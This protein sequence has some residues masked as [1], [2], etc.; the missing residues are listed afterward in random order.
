MVQFS[1]ISPVLF[2]LY[3]NNIPTPLHH[4]ALA[5]YMVDT[6]IIATSRKLT[7][8]VSYLES[9]PSDLQRWLSDRRITIKVSKSTT[10]IFASARQ[11]FIK[12]R[13]VKLFREPIQWFKT[14][15]MGVTLDTWLT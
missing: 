13:P 8:L 10:I 9:Y 1:I 15:N 3:V 7:L 12:P 6:T 11:H 2:S 14:R 5:L 4:V